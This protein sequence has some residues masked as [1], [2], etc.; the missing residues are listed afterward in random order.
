MAVA[1]LDSINLDPEPKQPPAP[2]PSWA[3][4]A[5]KPERPRL[6]YD[7]RWGS[8]RP[9]A[10]EVVAV[11]WADLQVQMPADPPDISKVMQEIKKKLTETLGKDAVV[12]SSSEVVGP[13]VDQRR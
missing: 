13:I 5:S 6:H 11:I 10:V 9:N 4:A 1:V 7:R 3:P 12:S 2:P 8:W